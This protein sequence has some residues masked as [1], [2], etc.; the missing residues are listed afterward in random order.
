MDARIKTNITDE[1][2]H[3]LNKVLGLQDKDALFIGMKPDTF[4]VLP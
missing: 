1:Q 4:T 2:F 3:N